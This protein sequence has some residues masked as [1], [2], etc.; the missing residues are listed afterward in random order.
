MFQEKDL[1]HLLEGLLDKYSK[2]FIFGLAVLLKRNKERYDLLHSF[3]KNDEKFL[4]DLELNSL[5]E[6]LKKEKEK[7]KQ[8][9]IT[10]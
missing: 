6:S 10:N 8:V 2:G 3:F 5:F 9:I 1:N 7:K 4:S